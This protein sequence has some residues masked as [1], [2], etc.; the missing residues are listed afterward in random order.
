MF[1]FS[2]Y[3]EKCSKSPSN[4]SDKSDLNL[5]RKVLRPLFWPLVTG[6]PMRHFKTRSEEGQRGPVVFSVLN[7][8]DSTI[9]IGW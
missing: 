8:S 7:V 1:S 3:E 5:F 4:V 9:D 6:S 2:D